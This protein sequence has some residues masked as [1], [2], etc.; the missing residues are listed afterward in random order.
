MRQLLW[1]CIAMIAGAFLAPPAA[2]HKTA[3]A[4]LEATVDGD[5]VDL[6]LITP[7]IDVAYAI[8]RKII[9]GETM[10]E[11][12]PM[13]ADLAANIESYFDQRV[14]VTLPE[15]GLCTAIGQSFSVAPHQADHMRIRRS[16][17]CPGAVTSIELG[18]DL[19]FNEDAD[20]RGLIMAVGP[21]GPQMEALVDRNSRIVQFAFDMG[22][23][24]AG[25]V[26]FLRLL[27]LGIEHIIEGVD[28]VLFLLVL[29]LGLPRLNQA[30]AVV[31]A[32]TVAHSVTLGLAWFGIVAL[33]SWLVEIAIALSIAYVAAENLFRR[34][35]RRR[36]LLAGAFGL[37]H[38]LGFYG[39]LAELGLEGADAATILFGFNL[40][41]EVGQIIIL[42]FAAPVL[43][44]VRR[45]EWKWVAVRY[46][47]VAFMAVALWFV[48]ERSFA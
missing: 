16:Y 22:S 40:G 26:T 47:S 20:H 35:M 7:V 36:W 45:Q 44:W 43:W 10:S 32:F 11:H 25:E 39:A 3:L 18:Y 42:A 12:E 9:P 41:V 5:K 37:I 14:R 1:L 24:S 19:F 21:S 30:I 46:A 15:K 13:P 34:D 48:F 29:L 17:R 31:T 8:R 4:R 38:G 28:H 23:Q 33:P 27:A 2:A 6:S